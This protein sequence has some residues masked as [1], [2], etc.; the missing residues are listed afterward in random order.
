MKM[1]GNTRKGSKIIN[2]TH[3]SD[4]ICNTLKAAYP[5]SDYV[6]AFEALNISYNGWLHFVLQ[7]GERHDNQDDEMLGFTK[8]LKFGY[9]QKQCSFHP[10]AEF[11]KTYKMPYRGFCLEGQI[12]LPK[13]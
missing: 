3:A 2:I 9:V 6:N 8:R 7:K 13:N 11:F 4:I 1:V 5:G 10:K 12:V